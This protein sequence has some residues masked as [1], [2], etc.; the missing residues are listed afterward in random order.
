MDLLNVLQIFT[1]S[2]LEG[3]S[4]TK[5]EEVYFKPNHGQC[6]HHWTYRITLQDERRFAVSFTD[7]QLGWLPNV[8]DWEDYSEKRVVR[9]IQCVPL[10][11][12]RT[13]MRSEVHT[14]LGLVPYDMV[15]ERRPAGWTPAD[16]LNHDERQAHYD[17]FKCRLE[18]KIEEYFAAWKGGVWA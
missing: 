17:A 16:I 15:L 18:Y 3:S 6:T 10:T 12:M 1:N 14:E 11:W 8:V 5:V 13:Q 2:V 9:V 7:R 4:V